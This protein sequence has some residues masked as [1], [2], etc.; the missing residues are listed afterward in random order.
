MFE[1]F[2]KNRTIGKA[3]YI[4]PP[5]P[6]NHHNMSQLT[7]TQREFGR[8]NTMKDITGK[9]TPRSVLN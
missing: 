6:F 1:T 3:T 5:L 8:S 4:H 2:L 9:L 7:W